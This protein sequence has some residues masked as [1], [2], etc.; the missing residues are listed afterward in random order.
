MGGGVMQQFVSDREQIRVLLVEDE[1]LIAEYVADSLAEQGF[2]VHAV[3]T[4]D[5]ALRYLSNAPVDVLFTDINLPG[6]MDGIMLARRARE[7]LPGLPVVYA[8]AR[9]FAL[10]PEARVPGSIFL[11][12]PYAPEQAG[13]LLAGIAPPMR[14]LA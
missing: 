2:A 12:K 3:A 5:E 8:S 11:P 10:E 7:L 14:V 9:L 4:A 13:R 6:D 1:F